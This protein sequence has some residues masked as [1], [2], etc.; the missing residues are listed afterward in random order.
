MT[1]AAI[2]FLGLGGAGLLVL[3]GWLG[4]AFPHGD[5]AST[6]MSIA[7]GP[8][9]GLI[10]AAWL[11]GTLVQG[12]AW[13]AGRDHV[14]SPR[15]VAVTAAWWIAPFLFAPP[16]GSRDVYSYA[17]QGELFGNGL[18]PYEYGVSELPCTWITAVSPIWRDTPAPYGPLFVLIAAAV[19]MTGSSLVAVVGLFRLL[20]VA[21]V[22]TVGLCLPTLA[23]RCGVPPA[24]A[25]WVALAG[26]LVGAH[27]IAGPHND[28]LIIALLVTALTV[29]AVRPDRPPAWLAAGMLLG[30]AIVV[31]ATAAVVVPFALLMVVRRPY[32][33][34][35]AAVSGGVLAVSAAA[36]TVA[37]TAA[38]G[39][40]V[41]WV[42]GMVHTRDLVQFT[43][44]PTAVGMTATYVGQM[45]SA[46]VD[47]VP[48]A[49]LIG[50]LLLAAVL[51]V[52]WWRRATVAGD[53][54]PAALHGAALAFTATVA[55]AP[56]FHPWYALAPL[57]L[58]AATTRRTDL[59]MVITVAAALLVLPDGGGLARF[60]KFPGAPLMTA[61]L[62]VLLVRFGRARQT[63]TAL[64]AGTARREPA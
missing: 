6:P 49:R 32:R 10:L 41:G 19:V 33:P 14:A 60:V 12:Y 21:G 27:L 54:V 3:A 47:L 37:V 46:S 39:L 22:I 61:L 51:L 24:R 29:L 63:P 13:W 58:L 20:A 35:Q 55:L 2:R 15:W 11:V 28:A 59:I 50:L 1:L 18:S 56:S 43:S 40:G 36:T 17:C 62:I 23:R 64:A 5:L 25:L 31:K 53:P 26:P 8:Y 57:I 45:A 4:G 9:G 42:A 38:A 52:V 16:M 48:A 30:L 44:P 7:R 34:G